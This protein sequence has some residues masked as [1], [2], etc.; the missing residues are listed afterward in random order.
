MS[1][2][3]ILIVWT[4]V[5]AEQ[6]A[7]FNAW[8][9]RQHLS[10][11]ANVP[12]FRNGRRYKAVHG[13]PAYL[14]WYELDSPAV[15]ASDAYAERQNN[16]TGWTQAVMPGFRDV[17]RVAGRVEAR[18]GQGLGGACAS[19]RLTPAAGAEAGLADWLAREALPQLLAQNTDILGAV[20][21]APLAAADDAGAASN[22][23]R[24]RAQPDN[25]PC[26]GLLIECADG[27]TAQ[28]VQARLDP[29]LL[30]R[31]GVER[32]EPGIYA[33]V[34]ALGRFDS[35]PAADPEDLVP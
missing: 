15:F 26:W 11:R 31:H 20:L 5:T 2:D 22:E 17:T 21:A 34:T 8:Y 13:A 12:G 24:M 28:G 3:G 9:N 32:S 7:R 1:G 29:T 23:T 10:E 27:E 14:A 30:A 33:L 35:T 16:P 19:W 25:P 18:L 6:D 4:G